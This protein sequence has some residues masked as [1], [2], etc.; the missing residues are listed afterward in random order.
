MIVIMRT[1]KQQAFAL[2]R[3]GKSYKAIAKELGMSVSTLSNWF[4]GVDFSEAVKSQLSKES[5][6]AGR[7]RLVDLNA[8]RGVLLKAHYEQAEKEALDE[9]RRYAANP[10]FVT[11]VS[12]Y[13]GEGDKTKN[14]HQVRLV[15]TDPRM[16]AVFKRFLIEI[17]GVEEEKMRAAMYIYGNLDEQTCKHYW[18]GHLGT[19]KFHKTMVL[20]GKHKTRR[21]QYGMLSLVVCS[22]YLKRKM[23]VWIDHLPEIVLNIPAD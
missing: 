10:L 12:A 1:D 16:L 8:A 9:L 5:Y 21:V 7:R 19:L 15:N 11:A 13:W 22:T 4:K 17:C 14:G 3:Q 20:P 23:L 2:R 18:A 6:E